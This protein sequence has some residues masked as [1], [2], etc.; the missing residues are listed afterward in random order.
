MQR[1]LSEL[2]RI[3]KIICSDLGT[4]NREFILWGFLGAFEML[5]KAIIDFTC[6]SV[7]RPSV[8]N[9][10]APTGEIFMKFQ[11]SWKLF[12]RAMA[13]AVNIR[14]VTLEIWAQ[15]HNNRCGICGVQIVTG[16]GFPLSN[17]D[18]YSQYYSTSTSQPYC[19]HPPLILHSLSIWLRL[20]ITHF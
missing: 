11:I 8:W 20:S 16:T 3:L 4:G 9:K 13:Q 19:I 2:V 14:P 17:P 10:S 5:R 18:F 15:C 1:W 7:R 6:L 12:G